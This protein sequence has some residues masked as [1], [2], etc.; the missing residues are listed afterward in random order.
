MKRLVLLYFHRDKY[1]GTILQLEVLL[2]AWFPQVM[3]QHHDGTSSL[4]NPMARVQPRWN[5]D[6]LH[7]PVKVND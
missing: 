7:I 1:M 5:Q 3:P 4:N 2:K 6:Q